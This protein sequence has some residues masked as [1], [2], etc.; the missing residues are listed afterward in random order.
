MVVRLDGGRAY[1]PANLILMTQSRHQ[2]FK[3]LYYMRLGFHAAPPKA[4]KKK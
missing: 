2:V 4:T 1:H 3:M